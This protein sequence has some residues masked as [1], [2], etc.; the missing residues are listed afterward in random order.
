MLGMEG[1]VNIMAVPKYIIGPVPMFHV[2]NI[3]NGI[4]LVLIV[5]YQ[6]EVHV[7]VLVIKDITY[8]I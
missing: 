8:Y 3:Y 7:F 4:N 5:D 6:N 1:H 2:L